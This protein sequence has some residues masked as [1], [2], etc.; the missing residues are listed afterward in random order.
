MGGHTGDHPEQT[1]HA[2]HPVPPG[3]EQGELD[4]HEEQVGA[5]QGAHPPDVG[6]EVGRDD[7]VDGHAPGVLDLEE[8]HQEPG[9]DGG[10]GQEHG[11]LGDGFEGL[12]AEHVADGRD[13]AEPGGG[14]HEEDV[15]G[16]HQPP[17]DLAGDAVGMLVADEHG[18]RAEGDANQGKDAQQADHAVVHPGTAAGEPPFLGQD[19]GQNILHDHDVFS[20][21]PVR[22]VR[23]GSARRS[24]LLISDRPTLR[25]TAE[26]SRQIALFA[27]GPQDRLD[28]QVEQGVEQCATQP[29]NEKQY[30]L[31][32]LLLDADAPEGG[33]GRDPERRACSLRTANAVVW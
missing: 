5:V 19:L 26:R 27:H 13:Q 7:V 24:L 4:E 14:D 3:L 20:S 31:H 33:A 2:G 18:V 6:A 25:P 10:D 17:R 23:R 11:P 16:Q 29:D 30:G 21:I 9:D 32:E 8:D 12:E 1:A 15:G 22:P 28:L